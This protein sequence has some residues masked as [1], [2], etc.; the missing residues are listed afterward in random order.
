MKNKISNFLFI[1]C[2]Y[3]FFILVKF[4]HLISFITAVKYWFPK[5]KQSVLY[6][7][8]FP[9]ENAGYQYRAYK[10]SEILKK[11]G[12]LSRVLTIEEDRSKFDILIK[13][14]KYLFIKGM[15]KR[16]IHLFI[17]LRY[18]TIIVRR[19]LLLYNEYG[20]LFM[21]KFLLSLHS[22]VIL[23]FDDDI[24]TTKKEGYPISLYGKLLL[25][26][27]HKFSKSVAI[28]KRFI[29]C[30]DWH[31]S[32]I[33]NINPAA[34]IKIIPTCVDR[35]NQALFKTYTP[36]NIIKIGWIGSDGNQIYLDKII[37]DLNQVNFE[38]SIELIVISGKK[39]TN[40]KANFKISNVKWSMETQY[41][42]LFK[43]DIGIMPLI[44]T[45]IESGKCGFKLLQY[46]SIGLISIA[47]PFAINKEI[48]K[49]N[50]NGFLAIESWYKTL[51]KV[52]ELKEKW[53][54]ISE[55]AI[56]TINQKYNFT[57]NTQELIS[58]LNV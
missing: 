21:E 24:A 1:P 52:I 17:S 26:N 49:N 53:P 55:N 22:N 31:V 35:N 38:F 33:K 41:F 28:Y 3:V 5:K 50:E 13:S 14:P 27:N 2:F 34:H 30:S 19:E 12:F 10:W 46:M 48:I 51:V 40:P 36:S 11:E 47:S 16:L 56:K 57:S 29:I 37:S 6:L 54:I 15:Y 23:D 44:D 25:E 45:G 42:D 39:Y 32:Y 43:L 18:K 58:Y 7:E 4:I 8:N 9:F 20:N